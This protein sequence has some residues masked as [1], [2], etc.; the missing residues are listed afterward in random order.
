[1]VDVEEEQGADAARLQRRLDAPLQAQPVGQI[2]ERVVQREVLDALRGQMLLRDV[3]RGAADAEH[4]AVVVEHDARI[5]AD[6][7]VFPGI[8]DEPRHVMLDLAVAF[9]CRQETAVGHVGVTGLEIKE[10]APEQILGRKPEDCVGGRIE[11]GE[12]P[13]RVGGPDEVVGGLDEIAVAVLALQQ[14]LDDAPLFRKRLADRRELLAG[15]VARGGEPGGAGEA[16]DQF[17]GVAPV[18]AVGASRDQHALL[19]PAPQLLDRNTEHLRHLLDAVLRRR[20]AHVLPPVRNRLPGGGLLP[21]PIAREMAHESIKSSTCWLTGAPRSRAPA[22]CQRNSRRQ[23]HRLRAAGREPSLAGACS[24]P[25]RRG[26]A[27]TA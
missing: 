24:S 27:R 23:A 5:D 26:P 8:G 6:P 14:E 7:A 13:E 19:V 15:L 18:P 20:I 11:I 2:G 3:T 22:I 17:A 21:G 9:Q 1:M 10:A 4:G 16:V 12:A 25:A